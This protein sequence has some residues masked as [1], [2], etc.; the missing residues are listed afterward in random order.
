VVLNPAIFDRVAR[1]AKLF[2][3]CLPNLESKIARSKMS[4][5]HWFH[6]NV[7]PIT[8]GAIHFLDTPFNPFKFVQVHW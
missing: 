8:A 6:K 3:V 4:T 5:Q 2:A 1:W 7:K